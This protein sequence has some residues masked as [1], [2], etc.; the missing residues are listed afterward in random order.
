MLA[1]REYLAMQQVQLRVVSLSGGQ[2]T[3]LGQAV[4]SLEAAADGAPAEFD[5]NVE[6]L[7]VPA[8]FNLRGTVSIMYTKTL[9]EDHPLSTRGARVG[10]SMSSS[11]L[12]R[13]DRPRPVAHSVA[14][15]NSDAVLPE[16]AQSM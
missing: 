2:P 9:A 8:G 1:Q 12:R 14:M 11:F 5:V 6:R 3:E 7:T 4:F 16:V 15:A 13:P 10:N